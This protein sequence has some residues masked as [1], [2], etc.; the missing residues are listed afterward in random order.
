MKPAVMQLGRYG[1]ILNILP[2]LFYLNEKGQR[3]T[4]YVAR[5]FESIRNYISYAD[6]EAYPGAYEDFHGACCYAR[7]KFNPILRASVYGKNFNY[8][9]EA[10]HFCH[11]AYQRCSPEYGKKF[12]KKEFEKIVL[13]VRQFAQEHVLIA[14]HIPN[15]NKPVVLINFA[16]CS[17]PLPESGKW[18]AIVKMELADEFHV[19]DLGEI[20]AQ[21]FFD[22]IGLYREADLLIT[23]D[24]GTLHLAGATDLPYIAFQNDLRDDWFMGYTRGNCILK[25]R[26]TQEGNARNQ[27]IHAARKALQCV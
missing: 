23:V 1:D 10:P 6:V 17:S 7:N 15:H 9:R 12:A 19:V 5:E 3:H 27:V 11:E 18:K 14:K 26:Y 21:S 20:R 25:V 4:L 16:A 8:N 2:L 22:L 13:D 24:T